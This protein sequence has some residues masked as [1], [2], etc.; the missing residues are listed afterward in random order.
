VIDV[1]TE[2]GVEQGATILGPSSQGNPKEMQVRF[3]DGTVDDWDK[4]DFVFRGDDE[5]DDPNADTPRG[6]AAA[7]A[8][9]QEVVK[10]GTRDVAKI[11]KLRRASL[12]PA[13][14]N[15]AMTAA[16]AAADDQ[17]VDSLERDIKQL[18]DSLAQEKHAH[19]DTKQ[20][21]KELREKLA[22]ADARSEELQVSTD[23]SRTQLEEEVAAHE[24]T[25]LE[26]SEKGAALDKMS[27]QV[28]MLEATHAQTTAQSTAAVE[29][30]LGTAAAAQ[31]EATAARKALEECRK[32]QHGQQEAATLHGTKSDADK[33]LA[34]KD[35]EIA[36][37]QQKINSLEEIMLT[38][39]SSATL[40]WN[41]MDKMLTSDVLLNTDES[42]T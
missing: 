1:D 8:L 17:R 11:R 33:D 40:T 21:L 6:N 9:Q 15:A 38:D 23:R 37:L 22:V 2:D 31:A 4:E 36:R 19:A 42:W 32:L 41:M 7:I 14:A 35:G 29:A 20:E 39:R 27:V 24:A 34:T 5:E 26:S 25:K 10:H 16:A 28:T 13:D 12:E 3:A 30:A 18:S